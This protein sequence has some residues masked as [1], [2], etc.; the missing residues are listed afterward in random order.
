MQTA[1][2]DSS[3]S[4]SN[5][6]SCIRALIVDD[7]EIG[8]RLLRYLLAPIE[9]VEVIDEAAT[10]SE[11]RRK[12]VDLKPDLVFMDIEMLGGNGI[13]LLRSLESLPFVI[14]V[15]AH[16]EF[17]LPAFE[18]QAFD[19]VLKPVQQQRFIGSVLRARQ[20]ISERRLADLA[21]GIA[22]AAA[23]I[24]GDSAGLGAGRPAR[25]PSQ[26]TIRVRRRIFRLN[27]CDISWV[28]VASQYCRVHVKNDEYLLSRSLA[29]L[30]SELDPRWFYRV[31]RSAIVNAS[32]VSELRSSGDGGYSIYLFGGQI[33]PVSRSRR[34]IRR[35]L[36][37]AICARDR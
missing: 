23:Q 19:Y 27:V 25:Y 6:N 18:L 17:A 3:D 13:E 32:H 35:K 7:E 30:E 8:R 26:I 12:I 5:S 1:I 10:V 9:E 4:L 33:V 34:E 37:D 14:F 16:A 2:P 20:R 22:N 21:L 31:H 11:A 36:V 28:Q 24:S 29:S 15:T